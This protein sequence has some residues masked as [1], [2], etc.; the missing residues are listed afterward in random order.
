MENFREFLNPEPEPAK[1]TIEANIIEKNLTIDKETESDSQSDKEPIMELE[2][3]KEANLELILVEEQEPF[4]AA[5]PKHADSP[6][7]SLGSIPQPE[8][9]ISKL[10][11][12]LQIQE[13]KAPEAPEGQL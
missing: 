5:P 6:V 2:K 13:K 8:F 4:E 1:L 3:P 12:N 9:S 11:E 10:A 7:P